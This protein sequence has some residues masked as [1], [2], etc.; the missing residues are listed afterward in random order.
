MKKF[1]KYLFVL[2]HSNLVLHPPQ[3]KLITHRDICEYC[4]PA[5]I[6]WSLDI[7][8]LHVQEPG[9]CKLDIVREHHRR[10]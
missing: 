2:Y 5:R 9:C 7:L 3:N 6:C 4:K 8:H 10:I 1:D